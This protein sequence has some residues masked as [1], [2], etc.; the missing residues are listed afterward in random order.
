MTSAE[1][2]RSL[3][4]GICNTPPSSPRRRPCMRVVSTAKHHKESRNSDDS[5]DRVDLR[6]G[7]WRWA[8]WI[9]NTPSLCCASSLRRRA[10]RKPLADLFYPSPH[11]PVYAAHRLADMP[12]NC[13]APGHISYSPESLRGWSTTAAPPPV[14][15]LSVLCHVNHNCVTAGH[16]VVRVG[17][18][19]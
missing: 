16:I 10:S 5:E 9:S 11:L 3:K 8:R 19:W 6:V 17:V 12:K 4:S 1:R 13:A 18:S 2:S 14:R 15:V 7:A